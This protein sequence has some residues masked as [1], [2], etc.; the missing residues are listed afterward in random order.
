[1][2]HEAGSRFIETGWPVHHVK[3]MLGHENLEQTSTYLNVTL[4]G[5]KDSM[6]RF[7]EATSAGCKAVANVLAADPP[8][9]CNDGTSPDTNPLVN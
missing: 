5:L 4:V 7:D 9:P 8:L 6:R 1:L 2:R 3:N